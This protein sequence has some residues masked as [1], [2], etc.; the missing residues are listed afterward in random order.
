MEESGNIVPGSPAGGLD[1]RTRYLEILHGFAL[2]LASV[3]TLD[4]ILWNIAKVAIAELAFE[5]CVVYLVSDDRKQLVQVA[6]HG[7][8][9]PVA[10]TI[11]NPIYIP[12]GKGIVGTVAQSGEVVLVADTREDPRYIVDDQV[13]LSELAVPI[14]HGGRV[15]GVLDSEHSQPGF[16][17]SEHVQ[18]LTTIAALASSRIEAALA[19]QKLEATVGKLRA[20]ERRLAAQAME[21]RSAKAD[22]D[23]ASLAK[24][25][26]LASMS[27][28]IRT[29]M[30]AIIGF[31]ELVTRPGQDPA[32]LK[33]WSHQL[34]RNADH[35]LGLVGNVLDLSKIESGTLVADICPRQLSGLLNEVMELMG[36]R[37]RDKGLGF[38]LDIQG[39]VPEYIATDEIRFKQVLINLLSNAIKYTFSGGVTLRV[40]AEVSEARRVFLNLAVEDTGIGIAENLR[41]ALFD[42]FSRIHDPQEYG[43]IE[44]TGLGLAIAQGLAELLGGGIH[45]ASE[46]GKGSVFT[47][48]IDVGEVDSLHLVDA[49]AIATADPVVEADGTGIPGAGRLAGCRVLVCEDSAAIAQI[50]VYLLEE[51]GAVVTHCE[52]GALGVE[53][54]QEA[55]PDLVLMD[56][57]MP[58]MDGYEASRTL[59]DR[60]YR[61]PIVAL[62]AFTMSDDEQRCLAAGCDHYI[63]KPITPARFIGQLL[64]C[65]SE[66]GD[67]GS[68][69]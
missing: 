10:R 2:S 34:K 59:R 17:T 62:T 11:F 3:D 12:M 8:K 1:S 58:V 60:G 13:R 56:I 68:A 29:P 37:A 5:D 54:V 63:Q 9:N 47:A 40:S 33:Q 65:L 51:A 55:L 16:Y 57:Q 15:I 24:S 45:V 4:S 26:F 35:L 64:E 32:Q 6:A 50:L 27:H 67:H 19:L 21:L 25:K 31:A 38:A 30:T 22:A 20:T 66:T 69:G 39:R 49:E 7:P 41:S 43:Q 42:P 23:Q 36:P 61:G 53:A 46:P 52:N 44:G 28:E 48:L 14:I 18:L